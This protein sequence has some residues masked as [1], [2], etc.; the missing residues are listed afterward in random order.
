MSHAG[1]KRG[2]IE[3]TGIVALYPDSELDRDAFYK[4]RINP[5]VPSTGAGVI[6][7]DN[8][9]MHH[10]ENYSRF[11]WVTDIL[12]FIDHIYEEVAHNAQH[13][14]ANTVQ[15][16]TDGMKTKLDELVV[17]GALVPPRNPAVD[18][19]QPYVLTVKQL[20]IDMWSVQWDVCPTG[21][22]RRITGQPKM[23][24]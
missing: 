9:T 24:K 20:K 11:G 16:L 17:S 10:L 15:I 5:V 12:D 3:R 2:F 22:A 18:G 6:I 8:L 19:N 21:S 23:V 4:A 7:D 13:D 14:D 1:E